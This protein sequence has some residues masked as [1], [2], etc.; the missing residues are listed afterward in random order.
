M[1]ITEALAEIKTIGKRIAKK[2]E[3]ILA[4]LVRQGNVRD[5]LDKQGGSWK[6]IQEEQQA[7]RDLA[8]RI[9]A[10]RTMIQR[11]NQTTRL[12]LNG[13][14]LFV[15]EWLAWRKE[16]API[17]KQY[18]DQVWQ[19]VSGAR[20][21]YQKQGLNVRKATEETGEAVDILIHVD[22]RALAEE[23]EK[24]EATL[25]DLDGKLSILNATTEI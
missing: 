20:P 3:F 7:I 15:T 14:S 12:S 4:H 21:H 1:T 16:A 13:T 10:L 23:R 18:L 11:S 24:L 25:G 6:L 2:Q 19:H 9:V 17:L 8:M 5:P 22:E